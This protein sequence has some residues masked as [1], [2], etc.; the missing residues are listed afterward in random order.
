[1]M[2]DTVSTTMPLMLAVSSMRMPSRSVVGLC[3]P[4]QTPSSR[5]P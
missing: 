3:L 5:M 4:G 1:M 2:A